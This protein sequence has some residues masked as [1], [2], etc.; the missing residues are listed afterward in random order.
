MTIIFCRDATNI[1]PKFL[2]QKGKSKEKILIINL[3]NFPSEIEANFCGDYLSESM[4]TN[5]IV[6]KESF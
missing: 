3:T 5:K 6:L 4:S 1:K 2:V